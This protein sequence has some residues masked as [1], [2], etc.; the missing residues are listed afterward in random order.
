M[1][2]DFAALAMAVVSG[3]A[4]VRACLVVSR[5]GLALGAYPPSEEEKALTVWSRMAALGDVERGFV[6][7]RDEVWAFSRR[8]PYSALATGHPSARAGIVL[9]ALDQL[10]LATEEA[11]VRKEAIRPS[12]DKEATPEP[13]RGPRTALHP[14]PREDSA[15]PGQ[16]EASP[17]PSLEQLAVSSWVE[18]LREQALRAGQGENEQAGEVSTPAAEE[19]PDV[20]PR[21]T[22]A[23]WEVDRAALNREFAG[24]FDERQGDEGE[25]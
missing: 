3:V 16:A 23:G 25:R 11:R 1:S 6:G 19:G 4:D 10:L 2:V 13:A 22:R 18:R 17:R 5:D 14:A 12:H 8:G 24:L 21:E 9:D 7:M 15:Q 20:R